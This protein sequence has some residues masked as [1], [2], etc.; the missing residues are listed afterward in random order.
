[1]EVAKPGAFLVDIIPWLKYVPAWVPG[2]DFQRKGKD[3][4][5]AQRS[6]VNDTWDAFSKALVSQAIYPPP[7]YS[8]I[9]KSQAAGSTKST[10]CSRHLARLSSNRDNSAQEL[11]I[12]E[13]ATSIYSGLSLVNFTQ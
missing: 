1:M 10:F 9:R 3:W 13:T 5:D 8:L 12:R 7:E 2:A 6:A 11:I 4:R